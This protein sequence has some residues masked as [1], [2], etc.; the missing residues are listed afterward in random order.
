MPLQYRSPGSRDSWHYFQKYHR[1]AA[2]RLL[3]SAILY[4][5]MTGLAAGL[6]LLGLRLAFKS[7]FV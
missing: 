7:M 2:C 3:R 4:A 1:L 6:V 5:V